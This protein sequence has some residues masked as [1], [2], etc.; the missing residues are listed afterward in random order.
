MNNST[1]QNIDDLMNA[2]SPLVVDFWA[3]WCMPCRMVAPVLDKLAERYEGQVRL[4]K[5]NVD[6]NPEVADAFG[7]RGIPTLVG[8]SEGDIKGQI[9]G[10]Q[11]EDEIARLFDKAAAAAPVAIRRTAAS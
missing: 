11:G 8:L 6:E 10:V 3:P 4:V 7:V 2:D 9:V 5:V 1:P